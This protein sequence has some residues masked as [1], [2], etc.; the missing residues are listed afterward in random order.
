MDKL[1]RNEFDITKY[2]DKLTNNL[3]VIISVTVTG[4]NEVSFNPTLFILI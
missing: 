3:Y 4:I 1:V 2:I